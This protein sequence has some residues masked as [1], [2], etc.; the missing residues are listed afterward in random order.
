MA[1]VP[2]GT[3]IGSLDR[4]AVTG[5]SSAAPNDTLKRSHQIATLVRSFRS[6]LAGI[7]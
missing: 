2:E 7:S 5:L 3:L 4:Y 6:T 1:D